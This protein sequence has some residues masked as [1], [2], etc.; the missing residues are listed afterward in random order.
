MTFYTEH[1]GCTVR[2]DTPMGDNGWRWVELA[3]PGAET[4]LHFVRREDDAPSSEPV[5]VLVADDVG[6]TIAALR[7]GS[8]PI[9]AE[10]AEAPFQ[11]GHTAA[12][13]QDSEGNQAALAADLTDKQ[14]ATPS[15]CTELR[16]HHEDASHR[17]WNVTARGSARRVED[18]ATINKV[19]GNPNL[20][21]WQAA[22][23]RL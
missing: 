9:L 10:P 13:F 16:N 23:G 20:Q 2:A 14:W 17:G 4:A 7:D 6:A 12:A 8:V 1:L 11:P 3:F 15:Q 21:P 19:L 22:C 18:R 5:L